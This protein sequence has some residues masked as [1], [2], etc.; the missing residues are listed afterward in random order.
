MS[1]CWA[2]GQKPCPEQVGVFKANR[3]G[4]LWDA[5]NS[6][7]VLEFDQAEGKGLSSTCVAQRVKQ[8]RCLVDGIC[9]VGVIVLVDFG[10]D[11]REGVLLAVLV[12]PAPVRAVETVL[13]YE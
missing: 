3:F 10:E 1:R 13:S 6:D 5:W 7:H 4:V 2:A 8:W 12:I 11:V 9:E